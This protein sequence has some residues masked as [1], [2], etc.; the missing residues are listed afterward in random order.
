MEHH[1]RDSLTA[2]RGQASRADV[3]LCDV[4]SS[5]A[6]IR[7]LHPLILL[8]QRCASR[9]IIDELCAQARVQLHITMDLSSIEVIKRFVRINA[10]LSVVPAIAIPEEVQASG[11][12]AVAIHDVRNRPRH[13]MGVI[14][15]KGRYLPLAA[16]SFLQEL[17]ACCTPVRL[18]PTR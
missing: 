4:P 9:R 15:K 3:F 10:G 7:L 17:Q 6:I 13:T 18:T 8:D 12:A 2:P 16:R 14:D 11:L 1:Q 5:A